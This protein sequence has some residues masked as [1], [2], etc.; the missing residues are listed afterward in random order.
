[1][2][3]VLSFL[4]LSACLGG[5]ALARPE[6]VLG[7]SAALAD[8]PVPGDRARVRLTLRN[9]SKVELSV[10]LPL[11]CSYRYHYFRSVP[12]SRP[13]SEGRVGFGGSVEGEMS[14]VVCTRQ[15]RPEYYSPLTRVVLAPGASVQIEE[16]L[17]VE[18]DMKFDWGRDHIR[19]VFE[20]DLSRVK[21]RDR[22]PI[23]PTSYDVPL[24]VKPVSG[25]GGS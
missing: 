4:L 2:N 5:E 10:A 9:R 20:L 13:L 23:L 16:D 18:D 8:G 11:L 19:I 21:R 12:S 24:E 15:S 25:P 22:K 6:E 7:I 14:T 3:A 17:P 1:M